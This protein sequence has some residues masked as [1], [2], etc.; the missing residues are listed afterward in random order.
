M[1]RIILDLQQILVT[2]TMSNRNETELNW[3]ESN[4][5]EWTKLVGM[6]KK[7]IIRD[8]HDEIEAQCKLLCDE[9]ANHMKVR[10]YTRALNVYKKVNITYTI[11][12]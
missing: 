7:R 5:F 10:N 12:I 6:P 4:W 2:V 1:I 8:P 9:A 11:T 3:I